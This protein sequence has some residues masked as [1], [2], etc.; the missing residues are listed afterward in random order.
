MSASA[1]FLPS[2]QTYAK[3]EWEEGWGLGGGGG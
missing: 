2:F 3:T 1:P